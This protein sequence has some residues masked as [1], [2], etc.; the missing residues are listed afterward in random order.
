MASSEFATDLLVGEKKHPSSI[1]IE[2]FLSLR[3]KLRGGG[4][5]G[6]TPMMKLYPN[7]QQMHKLDG[8]PINFLFGGH[9]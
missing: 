9:I 2:R 3:G 7:S 5:R 4:L 6:L 1:S 8:V